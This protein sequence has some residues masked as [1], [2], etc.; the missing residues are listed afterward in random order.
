MEIID[1]IVDFIFPKI[2]LIS[3]V[4]LDEDNSNPYV[5]DHE[6]KSLERIN[7][8]DQSELEKKINADYSFSAF[9]FRENDNFS[10]II[11]QIKYGGMK[12]LGF[13][14]GRI[15]GQELHNHINKFNIAPFDL[16]IPVPLYKTKLRERGYNQSDYLCQGINE[17]FHTKVIADIIHRK[18]NTK[19]QSKLNNQQR[20]QNVKGAFEINNRVSEIF[21]KNIILVD[22]VVTTG[23]TL[24]EVIK[25]L[26]DSNSGKILVCTLAM[27][28]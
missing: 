4:R 19:T 23:S 16:I 11:Y 14:M 5:N 25:T 6:I 17:I 7:S 2:C 27:A 26:K 3:D 10:R 9:T 12:K 13:Y 22:D 15:L 28:R 1:D 21:E 24:N 18:R 20:A 8:F